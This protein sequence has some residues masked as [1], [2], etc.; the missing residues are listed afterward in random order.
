VA[1]GFAENVNVEVPEAVAGL[2]ENCAVTLAGKPETLN[3]TEL[4]LPMAVSDTVTWV[5]LLR[6]TDAVLGADSEKSDDDCTVTDNAVVC[7]RV[8]SVPLTVSE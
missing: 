5:L 1:A 7:V 2:G 4:L 6:A 3:V 8:P